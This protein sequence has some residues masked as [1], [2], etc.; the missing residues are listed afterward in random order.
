MQI[1]CQKYYVQFYYKK[2][3]DSYNQAAYESMGVKDQFIIN[4]MD[5]VDTSIIS[6]T[7]I[8][9]STNLVTPGSY[10]FTANT[11][12]YANSSE[13]VHSYVA[14][15]LTNVSTETYAELDLQ[16]TYRFYSFSLFIK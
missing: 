2:N 1:L 16:T 15:D 11:T 7:N 9:L 13:T 12:I 8:D 3:Y 10:G 4:S 6:E 14:V 5:L